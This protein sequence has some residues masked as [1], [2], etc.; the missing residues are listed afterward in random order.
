VEI[1]AP[2][3]RLISTIQKKTERKD[4]AKQLAAKDHLS[5]PANKTQEYLL[6]FFI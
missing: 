5:Q 1:N 6:R 2:A 3:S 4:E